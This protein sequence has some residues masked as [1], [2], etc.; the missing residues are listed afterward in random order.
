M[1]KIEVRYDRH[2]DRWLVIKGRDVRYS[3]PTT[4][5]Q[6]DDK[7]D[8]ET[9][10][11]VEGRRLHKDTGQVVELVIK[12]LDGTIGE[13]STYGKDPKRSKN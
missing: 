2:I 10:G 5:S 1:L 12:R 11:R 3:E 4:L 7:D 8:A 9:R 13:R 6:H